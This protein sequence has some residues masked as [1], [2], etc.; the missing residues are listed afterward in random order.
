MKSVR[1]EV[2]KNSA[3]CSWL[4]AWEYCSLP[5]SPW[6]SSPSLFPTQLS[7]WG[8]N[9]KVNVPESPAWRKPP[10]AWLP[11]HTA[12]PCC[13]ADPEQEPCCIGKCSHLT[14]HWNSILRNRQGAAR[15][16]CSPPCLWDGVNSC[17]PC[18]LQT[19]DAGLR[20][21]WEPFLWLQSFW[22]SIELK[23]GES[24]QT[25]S[26]PIETIPGVS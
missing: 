10:Y 5:A 2:A 4:H 1:E 24:M 6:L 21:V 26:L 20:E 15:S 7:G 8:S 25:F 14:V 11:S 22:F 13:P 9:W 23:P 16:C 17:S 12:S 19:S 18:L 3:P